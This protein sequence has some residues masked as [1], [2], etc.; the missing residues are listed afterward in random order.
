MTDITYVAFLFA[1]TTAIHSKLTFTL[2][3]TGMNVIAERKDN[4]NA[5]RLAMGF[6][7]LE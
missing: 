1:I 5:L 6:K 2:F 7:L 3:W 4:V